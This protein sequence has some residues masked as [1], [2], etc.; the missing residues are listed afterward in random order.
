MQ[1][2]M[3]AAALKASEQF[4]IERTTQMMLGHYQRLMQNTKPLRQKLEERLR[5]ILEEFLR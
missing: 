3:G 2:K 5:T 4:S 1:K